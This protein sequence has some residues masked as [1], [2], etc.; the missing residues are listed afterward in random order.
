[1]QTYNGTAYQTVT[2]QVQSLKSLSGKG[3]TNVGV[4]PGTEAR[5]GGCVAFPVSSD[6]AVLLRVKGR[7]DLDGEITKA[8]KKLEK[9]RAAITKQQKL[10]ADPGYLAKVSAALQD[11]DRRRLLDYESEAKGFEATIKQFEDLKL[12]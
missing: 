11:A 2:E 8:A 6:A 7:V 9:T 10:L 12:E 3:V 5:P 4:V 1:M